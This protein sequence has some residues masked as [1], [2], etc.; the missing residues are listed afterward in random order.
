MI[1]LFVLAI[2]YFL[3]NHEFD[4]AHD[5]QKMKDLPRWC[6]IDAFELESVQLVARF[7]DFREVLS[8]RR[9]HDKLFQLIAVPALK[10]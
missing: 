9:L 10:C 4:V 6:S 3:R 5:E 1:K 8:G 2:T 7:P